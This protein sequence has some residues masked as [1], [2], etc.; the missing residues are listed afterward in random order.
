MTATV[1]PA[2]AAN[3]TFW[4]GRWAAAIRGEI[5]LLLRTPSG[6][7]GLPL[8]AIHLFVAIVGPF[9]TP[10]P[11]T[12]FHLE[13]R[14]TAPSADFLLGTDQFGR[15]LLSRILSGATSI[16]AMSIVGSALGI[17]IGTTIGISSGYRG[18]MVDE[19][20]MRI[21][22]GFMSFPG[23]LLALLVATMAREL[24]LPVIAPQLEEKIFIVLTITVVFIPRVAR[25]LRS[26]ALAIKELE[27][28]QSAR[29]RG[30][31]GWY[32]VFHEILPN[33]G[34]VLGVEA[35]VRLSYAILLA[36]SLGFLGLG[37]QPP[38]PDWGRMISESSQ[39][40]TTSITFTLV[41]AAA[42]ASLVIGINLVADGLREAHQL[43]K[44]VP[45]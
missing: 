14:L 42:I 38:S 40:I 35:S 13:A 6:R 41:P 36:A 34:A 22:D 23:L 3:E 28:V 32:I 43:P 26:A 5:L 4:V 45:Q 17:A 2:E 16:I 9:I 10:Y 39:F 30:E 15:D 20:I 37:V 25:V 18:G 27:F 11:H 33:T 24:E 31:P 12:E 44:E 1:T 29:L 7:V 21:M 19:V 8:V